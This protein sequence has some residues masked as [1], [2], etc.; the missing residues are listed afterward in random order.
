MVETFLMCKACGQHFETKSDLQDHVKICNGE[1]GLAG[2]QISSQQQ[3]AEKT[4]S[5]GNDSSWRGESD[6]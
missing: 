6:V 2:K 5:A 3:G 1:R 4:R